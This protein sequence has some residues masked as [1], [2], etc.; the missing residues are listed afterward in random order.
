MRYVLN[1][2]SLKQKPSTR[3]FVCEKHLARKDEAEQAATKRARDIECENHG[4]LVTRPWS[5]FA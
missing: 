2:Q 4:I 1:Q 5:F 3:S